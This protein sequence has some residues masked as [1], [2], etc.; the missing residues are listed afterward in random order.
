MSSIKS[1]I[2][3]QYDYYH[4]I[5]FGIVLLGLSVKF[6]LISILLAFYLVFLFF[7]KRDTFL[8]LIVIL[9]VFLVHFCFKEVNYYLLNQN[10]CE[11][12]VL[13]VTKMDRSYK[14]LIG[15][16]SAKCIIYTDEALK[17]GDYL[18][19]SGEANEYHQHYR[20]GF[21]YQS[22]LHFQNIV[23]VYQ[24]T[25]INKGNHIVTPYFLHEA[26]NNYLT[27]H[28]DGIAR[29]YLK[30]FITGASDELD[31]EEIN[32]LGISH[33]FVI[34]GLHVSLLLGIIKKITKLLK[35][36]KT[37]TI[38]ISLVFLGSYLFL[39]A[40]LVSVLRVV[41]GY[42]LKLIFKTSTLDLISMNFIIVTLLNPYYLWQTSFILSYAI[43]FFLS[44]YQPF[45]ICKRA[46]LNK[47]INL[48]LLTFF[49]QIFTLPIIVNFNPNLNILSI[50]V[51]PFYILIVSYV[52]LPL[53]I[54]TS[55]IYPLGPIYGV[56]ASIFQK[57]VENLANFKALMI[58]L[59][60][61]NI[62]YKLFYYGAFFL[63][64]RGIYSKKYF[65]LVIIPLIIG[66]WFGKG[67]FQLDTKILFLDMKVG[68]ACIITTPHQQTTI[69]IDTSDVTKNNELAM[70]LKN[71]GVRHIDYLILTHHDS[72]HSG[73]AQM[74]MEEIKTDTMITSFYE[75]SKLS[76]LESYCK[77]S[78]Y[79]K[80]PEHIEGPGLDLQV[81]SPT[82]DYGN[83]NDNS[84]VFI[85]TIE[86]IKLLNMGDASIK[87]ENNLSSKRI[88]V[89]LYKVAHHGS[90][91][92]SS[93]S[94]LKQI[95]YQYAVI[96]NG[97]GNQFGFP[98]EEVVKRFDERLLIT[99]DY[100]TIYFRVKKGKIKWIRPSRVRK[101]LW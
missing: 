57:S 37:I 50:I 36:N 39:T 91:T 20:F 76:F 43:A 8:V 100:Q 70:I 101:M 92:S 34:S 84:L 16:K 66:L 93:I 82:H 73:G 56:M 95:N 64:L 45:K 79:L 61:I 22:Y 4:F 68:D 52:I 3:S 5:V 59:G 23:G 60:N 86:G 74:L 75:K 53:S 15:L 42:V 1:R 24:N 48:W 78:Y 63:C 67:I 55:V 69:V 44:L 19:F 29:S 11:G 71:E 28:F 25:A 31:K 87:V 85:L 58:P 96:M 83:P 13:K 65:H 35:L 38:I 17:E 12:Y 72:D 6:I 54:I 89:D 51:N 10:E 27:T 94:F 80:A 40:F 30:V 14:C 46:L 41:V 47:I 26:V 32:T 97:Y 49:I 2:A 90:D 99:R 88:N 77:E 81:L 62:C 7:K 18:S 33:L 21:D 9:G 98:K